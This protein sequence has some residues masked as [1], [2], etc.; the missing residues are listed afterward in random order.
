[1]DCA[2][3]DT[4][5]LKANGVFPC[6]DDAGEVIPLGQLQEGF[7]LR[8]LMEGAR[9]GRIRSE[10]EAGRPPWPGT[11]E[12]CAFYRP[13][14]PLR[15]RPAGRITTFQVEPTL[16]CTLDC[17]G[18]SRVQQFRT[19][20]GPRSLTLDRF[21]QVLE[22]AVADRFAIDCIEYCGQGEPLSHP[23]FHH[24]VARAREVMP[25]TRQRVVTNG[26]HDYGT[27]IRGQHLDEVVVSCD[28]ASAGT[29][30][31]YR[32]SGD[33]DRVQ[34]FIADAARATP[35]PFVTW[36]YIVFEFND[37]ALELQRAQQLAI[38][39]GVDTL[40]FVITHSVGRSR[41]Y[42]P[43]NME[44]LLELAPFAAVTT[45]PILA[46]AGTGLSYCQARIDHRRGPFERLLA[47]TSGALAR[48]LSSP[49]RR[50][51]QELKARVLAPRAMLHLDETRVI[52]TH[53]VHLRG[54]AHD[55]REPFE[56]LT[57]SVNGCEAG[58]AVV[59]A[60][61]PDVRRAFPQLCS[62]RVGFAATIDLRDS[63][64]A[65]DFL[66]VRA[67]PRDQTRSQVFRVNVSRSPEAPQR[68]G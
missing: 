35:R 61:R 8:G 32:R 67:T 47:T 41:R 55:G 53:A 18:C 6:H 37:S 11:C 62:D 54:W 58:S 68:A 49:V 7:S 66:E 21:G 23:E 31:L 14:Q 43:R 28:G 29:Y 17:P 46:H 64:G 36:K 3:L 2:I 25:R 22:A 52:G 26:N 4:L 33:F 65:A 24:F 12:R 5:Y 1:M 50:R 15:A 40:L 57:L 44:Q 16:A 10:L 60:T 45:T 63:R 27:V 48:R 56:R 9:Y 42:T 30:P 38:D 13:H 34:A 59:G 51:V 39:H 19:R 20:P